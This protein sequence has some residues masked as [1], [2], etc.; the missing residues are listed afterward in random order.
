[1]NIKIKTNNVSP[2][3]SNSGTL[4]YDQV[5]NVLKTQIPEDDFIFTKRT[6]GSGFLQWDL[7][8]EGWIAL[9]KADPLI[10]ADVIAEKELRFKHVMDIFG[11]QQL[12]AQKILTVPDNDFIFFRPKGNGLE[13]KITVWGY[14]YPTV[15]GG[16]SI[17]GRYAKKELQEVVVSFIYDGQLLPNYKFRI[18]GFERVTDVD[19]HM[20][21][22]TLPVGQ[23]YD[24]SLSDGSNITLAVIN[25]QREYSFDVTVFVSVVVVVNL[26]GR[27]L[28][29]A[30][31][32][33]SYWGH[34]ATI[35]TD[36]DGHATTSFPLDRM[37]GNCCV[38]VN[39]EIQQ[40]L[41]QVPSNLFQFDLKGTNR[42]LTPDPVPEPTPEPEPEPT[43]EP[44]PE[45]TP[46]PEPE[47]I[48]HDGKIMVRVEDET[49]IPIGNTRIHFEQ[50]NHPEI[51]G[52]LDDNGIFYLDQGCYST[53]CP[54]R[55]TLTINNKE[56]PSIVFNLEDGEN[57]YLLQA[58][59]KKRGNM[60]WLEALLAIAGI[61]ACGITFIVIMEILSL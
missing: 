38:R 25:G 46:E 45:P 18:N 31:C 43:P 4:S 26:D 48:N 61:L 8:G 22:G 39:E 33:I 1:M 50:E 15:V 44:E 7:P 21:L 56:L 49:G 53:G 29:D 27:P 54:L 28:P 55:V 52:Q 5:Y 35:I 47:P 36:A 51:K 14:K 19:G 41:L 6:P 13:I 17:V 9:S 3:F 10:A 57:E 16:S 40:R 12:L 59:S 58:V 42:E 34:T 24:I 30:V 37:A 60:G 2:L 32:E 20:V 23:S 11:S